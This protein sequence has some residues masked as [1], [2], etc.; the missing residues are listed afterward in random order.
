MDGVGRLSSSRIKL[1]VKRKQGRGFL[2]AL[3]FHISG[4]VDGHAGL[5]NSVSLL[6]WHHGSESLSRY[7]ALPADVK[8]RRARQTARMLAYY[9]K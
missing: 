5:L 9:G 1:R 3:N 7:Q 2:A 8:A 6:N 4:G